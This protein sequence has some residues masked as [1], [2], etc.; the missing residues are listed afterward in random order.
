MTVCW[1]I[2][3]LSIKRCPNSSTSRHVDRP[4]HVARP[5]LYSPRDKSLGCSE[6]HVRCYD[7]VWR[8]ATKQLGGSA[9]TVCWRTGLFI[10]VLP[11]LCFRSYK[12]AKYAGDSLGVCVPKNIRI[13]RGSVKLFKEINMC[14]LHAYSLRNRKRNRFYLAAWNADAV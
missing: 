1:M 4:A 2:D 11:S 14:F 8:L 7:E 3:Q 9:R 5:I 6:P 13:E 10:T 12:N